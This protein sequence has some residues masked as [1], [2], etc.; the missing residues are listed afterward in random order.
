[1]KYKLLL[2]ALLFSACLYADNQKPKTT[3]TEVTVY[4]EGAQLTRTASI[5]LEKGTTAFTFDKLSPYIQESSIQISG[6]K[7][8]TV[9]SINYGV[10]YLSNAENSEEVETLKKNIETL[11]DSITFEE[12]LISGFIEEMTLIQNNRKLG[13]ENEVVSLEKLKQLTDYFRKRITAI[14]TDIFKSNKK[15]ADYNKTINDLT[16]QLQAFNAEEDIKTGEITVKLNT[17]VTTNLDLI[18]K[19]NVTQAGWF[20]IYDLKA[21][22]INTPLELAYKA[23][24][25]QNT[26]NNWDN[27]QLT[28]S[29]SDPNT[30][31][32]KPDVNP[33]YLNFI[34]KYSAYNS[35]S[36]IKSY[37]YKYNPTIKT[38]S[39]VVSDENG[40]PLPSATVLIKGTSI[41]TTT[42]FDG[43]YTIQVEKG[44]ELIFSYVGYE[45][46]NIA[47][48]STTINTNL[49][50]DNNTLDEVIVIGY[51]T[52]NIS[53]T[54]SNYTNKVREMA[55]KEDWD[56]EPAIKI[57]GVGTINP[58]NPPL[59]VVNGVVVSQ[60]EIS[61]IDPN[62][63][64]NVE[65]LKN[66]SETA[67]YGSRGANGVI[68]VTTK[69]TT[70]N[71]DTIEEGITNTRFEIKKPYTIATNGDITVIEI[72]KYDVPA[73]YNY[74]TAPVINENVFLTAKIGN[75]EQY[76]LL[77]GEAN[78]Y[79][80]GSYS[81]KTNINPLS[82]TDS[83][84]V[85]LGVDPNVVVKR[86]QLDDFKKTTFI[87][88]NKVINKAFEIEI[89]NNKAS[90][91]DIVLLDR[92]PISQNKEIKIDNIETE[93]SNY[94][95]DKGIMKWKINLKSQKS[96]K[97]K[98]SYTVKYPKEKRVNL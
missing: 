33:K 98:F 61:N 39:G 63:I 37:N 57:R 73:K 47:I 40:L 44:Q 90:A 70:S 72:E 62:S 2:L 20:P 10:N 65:T 13:N 31:N 24:V 55:K 53:N 34:S 79:F 6:L 81:G 45:T 14:K 46:K 30:N 64:L 58:N 50:P 22:K 21:E 69:E 25:Y 17:D 18:I 43:K 82:T 94:N 27:V 91:I 92:I 88:N 4:L 26:G 68:V 78:V 74:F 80:E 52:N 59:F 32:I 42:D 96:E 19:Y 1:M 5:T 3:L 77:P 8:A 54:N 23:H 76:R 51:G 38:V 7:D 29:T 15:I 11:K 97:H 83:L 41:G 86:T 49:Y 60:N 84:T 95:E 56:D 16:K 28:L 9:L 48:H 36:V 67:I 35:N 12:N 71:G 87:G 93:T 66:S 85:S 89:K 75:W